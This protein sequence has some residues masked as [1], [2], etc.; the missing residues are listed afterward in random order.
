VEDLIAATQGGDR[1]GFSEVPDTIWATLCAQAAAQGE[2]G[3]FAA[4]LG[5]TGGGERRLSVDPQERF[6][7]VRHVERRDINLGGNVRAPLVAH[8]RVKPAGPALRF[9]VKHLSRTNTAPRQAQAR[10]LNT[11]ARQHTLPVIALGGQR[12]SGWAK[13][14]HGA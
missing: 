12:R 5:T 1:W 6:D 4:L 3:T 2:P 13:R 7:L 14:R 11:W 8:C 9:M 10:R